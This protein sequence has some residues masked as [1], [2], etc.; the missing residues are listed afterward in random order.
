MKTISQSTVPT[1]IISLE[2]GRIIAL[3]AIITIHAKPFS[4]TPLFNGEPWLSLVLNQA[5]RFAVPLFFLLAGYFIAPK[6]I[7]APLQTLKRYS[8]PL[9]KVWFFW[10]I[11]YLLAPYNLTLLLEQGYLAEREGYWQFLLSTPLNTLFEGGLVHLWYVPA[12]ICATAIIAVLNQYQKV[13]LLLPIAIILYMY[14]LAAGSYQPIFG[15]EAPIFTRNG[16]FFSCLLVAIGFEIRRVNWRCEFNIAMLMA[17]LGMA[18][19]FTEA[20][21]LLHYDM[22][23]NTHDFL[24]GTPIWAVGLFMMLLK[25]PNFGGKR[26][27]I[28][29]S[30]LHTSKDVLGVYLIHLL[31]IIY[32][33]NIATMLSIESIWLDIMIVPLVFFQSLL[34]TRGI[35]R[36]PLRHLLLR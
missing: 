31:I 7:S 9:L 36:T 30:I 8:L 29:N 28:K 11:I 4:T 19:H 18:M 27:V 35:E 15:L 5:G 14:G 12:L 26:T 13:A 34:I 24:I 6:L 22:P 32:V 33:F 1:K 17:V 21:Y 2:W 10:S 16:P 25:K 3:I 23:F 20:R